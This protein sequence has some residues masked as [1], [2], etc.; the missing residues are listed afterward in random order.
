MESKNQNLI[1][2]II[3]TE[4]ISNRKTLHSNSDDEVKMSEVVSHCFPHR[5]LEAITQW[6][7]SE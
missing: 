7:W 1:E 6:L 2:K 3:A 5:L 4:R